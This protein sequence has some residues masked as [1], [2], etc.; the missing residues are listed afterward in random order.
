MAWLTEAKRLNK[1]TGKKEVYFA[2]QWRESG[3]TRT[4]GLGF[5]A[6]TE[7]KQLLKMFEG[8]LA[9]GEAVEPMS[10]AP[11]SA[12]VEAQAPESV[13]LGVYLA[14]VYIPV[15]ARDKAAG[16]ARSAR[17]A[18]R[19]LTKEFGTLPLSAITFKLVDAYFTKRRS[20]GRRP[21]TV[22]IELWLLRACLQHAVNCGDLPSGMPLLP[23]VRSGDRYVSPYLTPE[24]SV[25]VLEALRPDREQPHVVTRG[26]PPLPRD[27]LTFTAVLMALN[28]GM[29]KG[30][31]LTRG[32]ED[33]RWSTGPHGMLIVDAK[34]EIGFAVKTR[35]ARVIPLT[36]A[37]HDELVS[38]HRKAGGPERGWIFPA[39]HDPLVPR[40]DFKKGLAN[41]C[42]RAGVPVV[43][44]H[45]L[46]HTWATRLA[47]A[48]VDRRTLMDLGGWTSSSV[49]DEIYSH[50]PEDHKAGVMART[51]LGLGS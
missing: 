43:H 36:P 28:T 27:R 10:T 34:P 19:S 37:L 44:P 9:A 38:L 32:W 25:R 5:V 30:E 49:L 35:R 11:G 1:D 14:D 48:G 17:C 45:A 46:R 31:I 26:A 2:I 23:T 24:Q 22:A 39:D 18:Q 33:V 13:T 50:A 42:R 40:R 20:A 51:G 15:V 21:R 16:T 6:A 12:V 3:K 8:R 47:T 4:R 41:A 29:R 7:A